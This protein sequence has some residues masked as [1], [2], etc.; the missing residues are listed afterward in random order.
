MSR[1]LGAAEL[2]REALLEAAAVQAP[3]ERVRARRAVE[4]GALDAA[5]CAPATRPSRRCRP[6]RREK[7]KVVGGRR[8]AQG[9]REREV[10]DQRHRAGR[11]HRREGGG[12]AGEDDGQD[13]GPPRSG[14]PAPPSKAAASPNSAT[15]RCAVAEQQRL[16]QRRVALQE[17]PDGRPARAA[18]TR[19]GR[20]RRP[21]GPSRGG[22]ATTSARCRPSPNRQQHTPSQTPAWMPRRRSRNPT[23]SR[24]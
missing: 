5:A 10:G 7:K 16:A 2:D 24:S 20:P 15:R 1:A 22:P 12:Q 9:Q 6:G 18:A 21:R 23:G 17:R 13:A 14:L 8:P 4:L 11:E 3:R 19:P